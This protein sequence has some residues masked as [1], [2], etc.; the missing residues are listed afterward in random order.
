MPLSELAKRSDEEILAVVDPI[1]DNLMDGST[2][3]DHA[4]HVR[5]FTD[6][7]KEIVTAEKL[8]EICKR[9]QAKWG[10]LGKREPVAVFRRENS[11]AVVW[12]QWCT[13]TEDE[14][15]AELVLIEEDGRY[16]VEHV[17]FF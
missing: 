9:Y 16:L 7:M 15:V 8:Q 1:M 10:Y 2:E 5:D 3:I 6:R 4:K 13:E 17:V 12:K 14:F 11:I